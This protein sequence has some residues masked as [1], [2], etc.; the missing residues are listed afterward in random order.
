MSCPF[1]LGATIFGSIVSSM[2]FISSGVNESRFRFSANGKSCVPE[3]HLDHVESINEE[4]KKKRTVTILERGE[5]YIVASKPHAVVCHHSGWTGSRSKVKK[6]EDPEIP[7]LQRVRDGIHSIEVI[8]NKDA[9]LRKVNLVH[10][11][12]RGASGALLFAFADEDQGDDNDLSQIKSRAE[13]SALRGA[14]AT[15]IE[16][17]SSP[18]ATKT[19]IALVRG[20]GILHGEDLKEKGWFEVNR[21]IKNEKGKLNDAS[22]LFRFIASQAESHDESGDSLRRPRVS[23]VLARPLTGRWH[24]IRRHLNG[25]SHPILGDTSH[26]NNKANKEWRKLNMPGERTCLHLARL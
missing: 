14:T 19:Y 18:T 17:M 3:E 7:M 10:R 22:T 1:L 23:L 16:A 5:N 2:A 15:L 26:G 13:K 25:L 24:Q 9:A 21:P 11:L 6:G 20:E 8:E 12:D 4:I